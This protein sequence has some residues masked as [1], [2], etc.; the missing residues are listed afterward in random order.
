M[1]MSSSSAAGA[2]ARP[3]VAAADRLFGRDAA[4]LRVERRF[5]EAVPTALVVAG[6]RNVRGVP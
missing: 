3:A 4:R 5:L 2:V 6:T 1:S